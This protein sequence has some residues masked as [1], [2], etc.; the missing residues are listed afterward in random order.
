M[1]M[2]LEKALNMLDESHII[3]ERKRVSEM[4]PEEYQK[5]L[6]ARRKRREL[7]KQRSANIPAAN[8]PEKSKSDEELRRENARQI[9]KGYED[10]EKKINAEMDEI[11]RKAINLASMFNQDKEHEARRALKGLKELADEIESGNYLA[12]VR[13]AL[14]ASERLNKIQSNMRIIR[15]YIR[16][17]KKSRSMDPFRYLEIRF[18]E[19]TANGYTYTAT[20]TN[21]GRAMDEWGKDLR[22][23]AWDLPDKF[24]ARNT[25][26]SKAEFLK[27][28]KRLKLKFKEK[29]VAGTRRNRITWDTYNVYASSFTLSGPDWTYG[30]T[31]SFEGDLKT[32]KLFV[33]SVK[34]NTGETLI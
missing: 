17:N 12:D 14:R 15:D 1:S 11:D 29:Y 27:W 28:L 18:K 7:R 32:S 4:T 22:I 34:T 23:Y 2:D 31:I 6:E 16:G 20:P 30:D 9:A 21:S 33:S 19:I 13:T 26:V 24:D 3:V 10:A 8:Q 25:K 5:D